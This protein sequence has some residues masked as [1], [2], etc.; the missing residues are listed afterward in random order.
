MTT[1]S[2]RLPDSVHRRVKEF[3]RKDNVS[4][5]QFIASAVSEKLA[6]FL[7]LEHLEAR[8]KRATRSAFEAAL[9]EVPDSPPQ[10]GD[11]LPDGL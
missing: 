2:L 6:A 9:A 4:V 3:A 7:T 8:A 11:E 5:N 10:E 1:M